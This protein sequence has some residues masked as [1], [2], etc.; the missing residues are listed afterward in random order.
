MTFRVAR[1]VVMAQ[2]GMGQACLLEIGRLEGSVWL[3]ARLL[4]GQRGALGRVCER[5]VESSPIWTKAGEEVGGV[6]WRTMSRPPQREAI[7]KGYRFEADIGKDVD[8]RRPAN[9][10]IG[11]PWREPIVVAGRHVDRYRDIGE[12]GAQELE[13][14]GPN[15]IKL[16]EVARRENRVAPFVGRELQDA[17]QCLP[18][19]AT[20][21][22]CRFR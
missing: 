6:G 5:D 15:S 10:E 22:P 11:T 20:A 12:C 3:L 14:I 21:Q 8:V 17:G 9:G 2:E 4:P 13:R 19:V 1:D 18:S 16:E 7:S